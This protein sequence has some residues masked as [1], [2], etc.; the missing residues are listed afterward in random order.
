MLLR[1]F[2]LI[3]KMFFREIVIE[4]RENLPASGPLILASNPLK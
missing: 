4:G 1:F 2:R 3:G